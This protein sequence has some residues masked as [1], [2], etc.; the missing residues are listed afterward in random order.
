LP[1]SRSAG[2]SNMPRMSRLGYQFAPSLD[3]AR[4]S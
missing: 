4:L 2:T 3:A 1:S